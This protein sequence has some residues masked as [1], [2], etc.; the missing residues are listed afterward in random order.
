MTPEQIEFQRAQLLKRCT[1]EHQLTLVSIGAL[2]EDKVTWKPDAEKAMTA[3]ELAAHAV[4]AAHFF[5]QQVE[6]RH[7]DEPPPGPPKTKDE[8]L[9]RVNA[10][11]ERYMAKLSSMTVEELGRELDFG[12]AKFRAIEVM[13]WHPWHMVHHRG[14][15][16]LYLR[17]MGARVPST[18]GPSGDEGPDGQ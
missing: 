11:S 2:P 13:S 5:V 14:Q 12:P 4:T 9:E 1:D 8:V 10:A 18:Y 6:G 3:G 16:Q 15:L 7:P 17:L